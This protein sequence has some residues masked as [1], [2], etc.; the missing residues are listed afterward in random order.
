[1]RHLPSHPFF[2]QPYAEHVFALQNGLSRFEPEVALA[3]ALGHEPPHHNDP[4][5][6]PDSFLADHGFEYIDGE[7]TRRPDMASASKETDE[8]NDDNHVVV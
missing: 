6:G 3:I 2:I 8:S 5:E 1:M 4:P 7:R